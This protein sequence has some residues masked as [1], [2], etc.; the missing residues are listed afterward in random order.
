MSRIALSCAAA[1]RVSV[2]VLGTAALERSQACLSAVAAVAPDVPFETIVMLDGASAAQGADLAD[3]LDGVRVEVSPVGLGLG[4]SLNRAREHC[5][6]EFLVMLHDDAI[7]RGGWLE[8][9]VAAAERDPGAGAVGSVSIGRDGRVRGAGSTLERDGSTHPR[10]VGDPPLLTELNTADAVDHSGAYSLLVRAATWDRVG[11]ADERFVSVSYV[12][13]DLCFA[14]RAR[15][16]RVLCEPRSVVVHEGGTSTTGE[17]ARFAA[18]RNRASFLAKWGALVAS[19]NPGLGAVQALRAEDLPRQERERDPVACERLQL[20]RAVAL[21]SDQAEE[22][23]ARARALES[24]RVALRYEVAGLRARAETLAAI[25]A[26]GWWRLRS[27]LLPLL[28]L[29]GRIRRE[30]RR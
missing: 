24:E 17:F 11:G 4:A 28:A 30:R 16:Q 13:V 23:G 27:R 8:A 21:L 26:G 10:W 18:H 29:Y 2:V 19:H 1:P 15:G 12:D 7:V 20:Q 14:I 22:L 25:E 9:L 6:G 3:S 5:R